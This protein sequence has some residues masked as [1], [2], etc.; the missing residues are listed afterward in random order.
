MYNWGAVGQALPNWTLGEGGWY[1]K[2]SHGISLHYVASKESTKHHVAKLD[3][4][5]AQPALKLRPVQKQ[6][7]LKKKRMGEAREDTRRTDL[8]LPWSF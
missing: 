4:G 7:K 8:T 6:K 1:G 3:C 2:R 5:I